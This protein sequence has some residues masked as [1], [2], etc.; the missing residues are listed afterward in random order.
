MTGA[1]LDETAARRRAQEL[2]TYAVSAEDVAERTGLSLSAVLAMRGDLREPEPEPEPPRPRSPMTRV[3]RIKQEVADKHGLAIREM[4]GP[5]R[6]RPLVY[7]RFELMARLR[8]ETRLSLHAIGRHCGGR[9]HSTVVH[10]I[11]RHLDR[12]EREAR[13]RAP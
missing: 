8:Q 12:L 6:K 9:D 7:A 1:P 2:L 11:K 10:G 3:M 5:C 4:I 13:G